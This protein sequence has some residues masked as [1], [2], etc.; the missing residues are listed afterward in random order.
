MNK[1]NTNSRGDVTINKPTGPI[2]PPSRRGTKAPTMEKRERL[3]R[4]D[5]GSTLKCLY[6]C[7][8]LQNMPHKQRKI[9][10]TNKKKTPCNN[11]YSTVPPP[12][13]FC[14]AKGMNSSNPKA[15]FHSHSLSLALCSF[16]HSRFLPFLHFLLLSF[17]SSVYSCLVMLVPPETLCLWRKRATKNNNTNKQNKQSC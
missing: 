13:E 15:L 10:K 6:M 16:S 17:L 1:E 7:V 12:C 14:G 4:Q 9:H 5:A 11:G 3:Q 2:M 8:A